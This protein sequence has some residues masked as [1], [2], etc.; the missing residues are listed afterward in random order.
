MKA[1]EISFKST[2]TAFTWYEFVN[3]DMHIKG[4]KASAQEY[5]RVM[6]R[7]SSDPMDYVQ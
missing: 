3:L 4:L 5:A 7:T 6:G 1:D 2:C